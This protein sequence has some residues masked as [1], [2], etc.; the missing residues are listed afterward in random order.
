MIPNDTVLV[1]LIAGAGWGL[2]VAFGAGMWFVIVMARRKL[3]AVSAMCVP[4]PLSAK[5]SG[6]AYEQKPPSPQCL[7]AHR[8]L[9]LAPPTTAKA[10]AALSAPRAARHAAGTPLAALLPPTVEP[11]TP[12]R[13]GARWWPSERPAREPAHLRVLPP[14]GIAPPL[15]VHAHEV[16][17]EVFRPAAPPRT[18]LGFI[19]L[20]PKPARDAMGNNGQTVSQSRRVG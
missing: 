15:V 11:L 8:P 10:R 12:K 7:V 13:R 17:P 1:L 9:A 2:A 18:L 6:L 19:R 5:G 3:R 16:L 20:K 14:P 4:A